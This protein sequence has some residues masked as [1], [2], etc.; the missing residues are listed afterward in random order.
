[1]TAPIAADIVADASVIPEP[2]TGFPHLITI[3]L[4]EH[5]VDLSL[6]TA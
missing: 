4:A 5:L 3:V 2:P 1:M 6:G